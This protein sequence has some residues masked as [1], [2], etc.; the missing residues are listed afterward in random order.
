[1]VNVILSKVLVL[2]T[3]TL[4]SVSAYAATYL[5]KDISGYG[6]IYDNDGDTNLRALP[7]LASVITAKVKSGTLV[8]CHNEGGRFGDF[9]FSTTPKGDG[10]IHASR[11]NDLQQ[12]N[13][14]LSTENNEILASDNLNVHITYKNNEYQS[15]C[16]SRP[17]HTPCIP[18]SYLDHIKGVEKGTHMVY[19]DTTSKK[20]YLTAS[21]INKQHIYNVIW[22]LNPDDS[23][24]RWIYAEQF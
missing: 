5:K 13:S 11:I 24:E 2:S 7:S 18:K 9:C 8:Y 16:F 22:T 15:I 3:I 23:I 21:Y 20:L 10:Y 12:G 14:V 1:M 17:H 6:V 4:L 19:S